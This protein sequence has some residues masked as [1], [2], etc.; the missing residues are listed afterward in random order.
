VSTKAEA[1]SRRLRQLET[2]QWQSGEELAALQGRQLAALAAHCEKASPQF[3]RRLAQAGLTASD[4]AAPG[5]LQRLPVLHRRDIQTA[6]DFYCDTMPEAHQPVFETRTSGSTGEPVAV[7][8]T[9]VS[10]LDWLATTMREH[11][12][13]NRD[14]V[15]SV[16]AIRANIVKTVRA[17][18]WG[19]PVSLLFQSGP[20]LG[21]PI[22]LDVTEQMRLIAQFK[23]H[24]LIVY[25]SNLAALVR[26]CRQ[27]GVAFAGLKQILTIGE[28][29]S[30]ETRALAEET[31]GAA[32]A[33]MYSSQELGTIALQCPTSP[34][35]HVMAENLIV[36]VLDA[37]GGACREGQTGRLVITDLRNYATPLIRYDIGDYAEVGPPCP[38]GRGLQTLTR[39]LGRERNL[40][41]MPDGTRHWPLVGFH[42]F[43]EIAPVAQYQF[44]QHARED[45]ELRLVTERPLTGDEEN[46]LRALI[47]KALGYPFALHLVYFEK[48]IPPAASGKFEEFVCL[49]GK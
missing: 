26:C 24:L 25:P 44:V 39:I 2:T 37:Q 22:T 29:L 33:D 32:V 34:L 28:T 5:G 41:L 17:D 48:R 45:I 11:L 3:R 27:N 18:D 16:C 12:W 31:F 20:I 40:I 47:Q 14:F 9:A 15:K 1:L 38:C 4:L 19:E 30:P 10:Q 21:L 35:Y 13:H 43:R 6:T 7:Q 42:K 23:P 46:N 8:R 36:E 49:V